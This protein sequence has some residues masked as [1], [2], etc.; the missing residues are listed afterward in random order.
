MLQ[1]VRH[2]YLNVIFGPRHKSFIATSFPQATE[3]VDC[4]DFLLQAVDGGRLHNIIIWN[5]ARM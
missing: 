2:A 4:L 3:R 1:H 5:Q